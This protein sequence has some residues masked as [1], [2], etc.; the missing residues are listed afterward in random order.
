MPFFGRD[1]RKPA[2]RDPQPEPRPSST[3]A[4]SSA[5]SNPS[6]SLATRIA[7]GLVIR[8]RLTGSDR[9]QID[10]EVV[11]EVVVDGAVTIGGRGR[12]DGR[13]EARS[14]MVE[15]KL[16]GDLLAAEKAEVA[17]SGSTEGDIEAPRVVIAEGAFFKGNVKM[18][19][20][21]TSGRPGG[22]GSGEESSS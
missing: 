8:G 20:Q 15:G 7:P 5:R 17:A 4:A 2:S 21:A 12:V 6:G 13:V 9:V 19:R 16:E 14:V 18:G 22:A 11:G 10:G 1:D 3:A